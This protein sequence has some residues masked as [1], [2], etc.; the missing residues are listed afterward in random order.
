MGG[1][2]VH[3]P[4]A[5]T[6]EHQRRQ[7]LPAEQGLAVEHSTQQ[8]VDYKVHK[9]K[10]GNAADGVVLH[11]QGPQ[12]IAGSADEGQIQQH[13]DAQRVHTAQMSAQ[14]SAQHEQCQ[15]THE[16]VDEADRKAVGLFGHGLVPRAGQGKDDR[17]Q[18]HAEDAPAAA[19]AV[20]AQR[21]DEHARKTDDTAQRFG[22]GHAVGVAVDEVGKDDA[23]KALGAVQDAAECAGEGSHRHVVKGILEGG[24]PQAQCTALCCH[25]SPGEPGHP[26]LQQ[27]TAQQHQKAAQH[28]PYSCKAEDGGGVGR[29]NGK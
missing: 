22:R 15:T 10:D 12:H 14:R 20:V 2:L 17:G 21:A 11:Q 19:A 4:D 3:Q 5:H 6:H 18:Q 23:Q 9:A 26:V 28:E 8:H 1:C 13:Q 16:Q 25:L 27:D 24:L 29:V 7:I